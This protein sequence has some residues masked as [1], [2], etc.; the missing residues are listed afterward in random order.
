MKVLHRRMEHEGSNGTAD[1]L[2]IELEDPG[3]AA[4]DARKLLHAKGR[5]HHDAIA[6]SK[7]SGILAVIMV[8]Y[9]RT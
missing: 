7:N 9:S 4:N 1:A 5:L 8:A 2:V 3:K 6:R